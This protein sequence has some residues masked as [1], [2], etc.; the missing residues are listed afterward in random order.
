MGI[1]KLVVCCAL[2]IAKHMLG[3]LPVRKARIFFFFLELGV[4]CQQLSLQDIVGY[5]MELY[6]GT[7][8]LLDNP[9]YIYNG[10]RW[11][12]GHREVK[13]RNGRRVSWGRPTGPTAMKRGKASRDEGE[14]TNIRQAGSQGLPIGRALIHL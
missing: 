12:R 13:D 7:T 11:T 5:C 1:D 6:Y 9:G 10:A 3:S 2:Q 8:A 4:Y 14:V